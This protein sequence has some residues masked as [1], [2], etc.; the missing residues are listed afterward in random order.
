MLNPAYKETPH[1]EGYVRHAGKPQSYA[2]QNSATSIFSPIVPCCHS[3]NEKSAYD[4]SIN[5]ALIIIKLT[6]TQV[7]HQ[8]HIGETGIVQ[9]MCTSEA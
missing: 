8:Q 1:V 4:Q 3:S 2:W 7:N 5:Q 9:N 6:K